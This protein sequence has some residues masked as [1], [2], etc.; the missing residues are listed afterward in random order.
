MKSLAAIFIQILGAFFLSYKHRSEFH[1][2]LCLWFRVNGVC[3]ACSGLV[4]SLGP[5]P[6]PNL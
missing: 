4:S 2:C 5:P 6:L 3:R 1:L